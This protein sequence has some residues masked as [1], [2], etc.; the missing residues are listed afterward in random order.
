MFFQSIAPAAQSVMDEPAPAENLTQ[1]QA[2]PNRSLKSID[3][4]PFSSLGLYFLQ[5]I[6]LTTN[7][8]QNL[9][10]QPNLS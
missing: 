7:T 5:R 10:H 4:S 1:N 3:A 8:N 9:G 6:H 2:N